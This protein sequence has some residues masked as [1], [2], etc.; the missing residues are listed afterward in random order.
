MLIKVKV[1]TESKK[2]EIVKKSD[3]SYYVYA[4]SKAEGGKANKEVKQILS[5]HF[6]VSQGKIKLLKGGLRPNK[7]FEIKI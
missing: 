6:Q 2:L 1:F 3:D 4:E 5:F 7:I